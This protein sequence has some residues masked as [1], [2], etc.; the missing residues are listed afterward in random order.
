MLLSANSKLLYRW[1]DP[2]KYNNIE[3]YIDAIEKQIVSEL[4]I[5]YNSVKFNFH[6]ELVEKNLLGG[7]IN[8]Y[9]ESY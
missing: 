6:N 7:I 9:L 4:H 3:R 1:F 2:F 8:E 5:T